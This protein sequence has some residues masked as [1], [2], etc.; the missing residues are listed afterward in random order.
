M[1]SMRPSFAL[2][3]SSLGATLLF[4]N[5]TIKSVEDDG[6]GGK[7]SSSGGSSTTTDKCTPGESNDCTCTNGKNGAQV[8]NSKGTGYNSCVCDGVVDTGGSSNAGGEG[9]TGGKSGSSGSSSGGADATGEGG[10]G[11]DPFANIDPEDCASC[12]AQLCPEQWMACEADTQCVSTDFD[13][14]GQ[15]EMIQ[16]N[17]VEPERVNGVVKRD[18]VRGCGVSLGQSTDPNF[19]ADWGPGINPAT[20]E[21][22][23]CMAMG[24]NP[25]TANGKPDASWANSEDNFPIVNQM[26]QPVPWPEGTCA[27]LACTGKTM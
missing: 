5:C 24:A 17:C 12:L 2:L 8:C 25:P 4:A 6:T 22:M 23:N 20:V 19:T 27:K 18:V 3:I 13:G 26:V 21:L 1:K 14:T 10:A 11:G 16:N 15:Y 9:N 7:G